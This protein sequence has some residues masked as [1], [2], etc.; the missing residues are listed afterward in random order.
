MDLHINLS[1]EQEKDFRNWAREN[2]KPGEEVCSAWHPVVV[3]E[4]KKMNEESENVTT[5]KEPEQTQ[6]DRIRKEVERHFNKFGLDQVQIALLKMH[7]S[8]HVIE[9]GTS[10]MC[11]KWKVDYPGGSFVQAI[12]DND[13]MQA[14]GRADNINEYFIKFYVQLLYNM[15]YVE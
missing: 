9:I 5:E 2:Y 6:R 4:C 3:D 12:V 8:D 7:G 14:V 10:V 1:P 13:L 11:T 15:Q